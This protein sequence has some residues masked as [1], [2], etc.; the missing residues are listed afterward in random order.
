MSFQPASGGFN[1]TAI[2]AAGTS[3]LTNRSTSLVRVVVPGTY[4]GTVNVFD[5]AT[6]AGTS[7]SNQIISLGIPATTVAGNI[8]VGAKCSNGLTYAA[9]GTPVLTL[10]WD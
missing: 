7:A 5:S 4:V 6:A 2:T 8:E 1:W 3:V 9:T 10:I